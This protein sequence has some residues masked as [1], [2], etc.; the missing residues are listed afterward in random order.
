[1]IRI[2]SL[3][4]A[5]LALAAVPAA[6]AAEDGFIMF[7]GP[8][9]VGA[10]GGAANRPEA[11]VVRGEKIVFTGSL[12]AA[13]LKGKGLPEIDLKGAAAYP[14]FTDSHVHLTGVGLREMTLNL[15]Q[16]KSVAELVEAVQAYAAAHPG[17]APIVGRG[18]IE[19]HWPEGR[20][21]NRADLDAVS[22]TRPIVLERADGHAV[23]LN[24]A[25]LNLAALAAIFFLPLVIRKARKKLR[26]LRPKAV[27]TNPRQSEIEALSRMFRQDPLNAF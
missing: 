8:I 19:T 6:R 27:K 23:V 5:L 25:A 26:R 14:G 16:V 22:A 17:D 13:R 12:T 10:I 15:D 18:W 4:F 21:P 24:T 7:G 9:Y 20:F 3:V 11:L 2:L 1:M